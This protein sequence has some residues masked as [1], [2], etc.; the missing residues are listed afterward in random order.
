MLDL[1]KDNLK[2][3]LISYPEV[4]YALQVLVAASP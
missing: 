4:A 2:G 3:P 1:D